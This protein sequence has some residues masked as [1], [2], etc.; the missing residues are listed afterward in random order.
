MRLPLASRRSMHRLEVIH[1]LKSKRSL[2]RILGM[3]GLEVAIEEATLLQ[4][5]SAEVVENRV[6]ASDNSTGIVE[7]LCLLHVEGDW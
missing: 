1:L 7:I 6:Q 5:D 3:R 2:V 4:L